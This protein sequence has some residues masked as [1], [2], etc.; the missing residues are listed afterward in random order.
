LTNAFSYDGIS[1]TC[2][3]SATAI[4]VVPAEVA[5]SIFSLVAE[6]VP[7]GTPDPVK[8]QTMEDSVPG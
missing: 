4:V 5:T 8:E 6:I 7:S 1:S 3:A 2:A